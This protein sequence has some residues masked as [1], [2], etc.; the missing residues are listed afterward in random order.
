MLRSRALLSRVQG[1]ATQGHLVTRSAP[2]ATRWASPTFFPRIKR[3]S[4]SAIACS[5]PLSGLC[6]GVWRWGFRFLWRTPAPPGFGIH[7][8]CGG[9]GARLPLYSRISVSM[10]HFGVSPQR[11]ILGAARGCDLWRR[12]VIRALNRSCEPGSVQG[13]VT[14]IYICPATPLEVARGPLLQSLIR[15]SFV[16]VWRN[17][18]TGDRMYN[19]TGIII[20]TLGRQIAS[21]FWQRCAGSGSFVASP[22]ISVAGKWSRRTRVSEIC[23]ARNARDRI[24]SL[25]VSS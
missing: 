18:L 4:S 5:R 10:A 16:A 1:G 25:G 11:F 12:L 15:E 14:R 7:R 23:L 13:Q 24:G 9:C 3:R 21:V 6:V 17:L 8:E 20:W 2:A 19:F 22:L